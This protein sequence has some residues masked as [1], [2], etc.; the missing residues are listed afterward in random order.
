M[1]AREEIIGQCLDAVDGF[2][3]GTEMVAV[4]LVSGQIEAELCHV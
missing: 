1:R 4:D 2:G 3:D